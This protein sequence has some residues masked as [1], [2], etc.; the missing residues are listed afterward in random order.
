MSISMSLGIVSESK[1]HEYQLRT[2]DMSVSWSTE[3]Q[4]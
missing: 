2:E 4:R 3:L 1:R